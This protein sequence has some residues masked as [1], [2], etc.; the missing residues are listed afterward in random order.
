[1]VGIMVDLLLPVPWWWFPLGLVALGWLVF[2]ASAFRGP[3]RHE[4]VWNA[5]IGVLRPELRAERMQEAQDERFR[6]TELPLFGMADW[7]GFRFIGGSRLEGDEM[8]A[9][10]LVFRM[11]VDADPP[12]V[13]VETARAGHAPIRLTQERLVDELAGMALR[14]AHGSPDDWFRDTNRLAAELGGRT[15]SEQDLPIDGA[16]TPFRVLR[17]RHAWVAVAS[18]N[19]HVV[20]IQAEGVAPEDIA[21]E[22]VIDVEPYIQGWRAFLAESRAAHG[23]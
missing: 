12:D 17:E 21:L 11:T 18:L 7:S 5:L 23:R 2:A 1:M 22:R 8:V 14:R 19:D 20:A 9:A 4:S 16:P 15:W 6:R 10:A 13:R 3:R